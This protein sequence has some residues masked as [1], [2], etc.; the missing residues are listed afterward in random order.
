MATTKKA[1]ATAEKETKKTTK[2]AAKTATKAAKTT[3]AA[4]EVKAEK[5]PAK[6]APAK[7][8]PAKKAAPKKTAPAKPVEAKVDFFVEYGGVQVSIAKVIEDVKA[9]YGKDAKEISVYLKPEESKAYFVADGEEKEMD[10]F[11][12]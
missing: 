1:A 12:C 5:A 11:F 2:T 6:K 9:T 4:E 10:V 3:K 8:A 7:K